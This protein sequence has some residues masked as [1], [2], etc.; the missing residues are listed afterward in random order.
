MIPHRLLAPLLATAASTTGAQSAIYGAGLQAWT[1]CWSAEQALTPAGGG[2]LVCIGPT[3]NVNVANV[4][5]LDGN[6]VAREMID[7]TGHPLPLEAQGWTGTRPAPGSRDSPGLFPRTP[8][9]C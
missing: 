6:V 9:A 4:T 8:G 2:A 7:A 5:S 1:G 3:T